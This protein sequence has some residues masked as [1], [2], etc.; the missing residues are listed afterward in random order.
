MANRSA[1]GKLGFLSLGAIAWSAIRMEA[2]TGPVVGQAPLDRDDPEGAV[3]RV[4]PT[5]LPAPEPDLSAE[6]R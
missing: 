6:C 2:S 5:A 3:V 4:L 1:S